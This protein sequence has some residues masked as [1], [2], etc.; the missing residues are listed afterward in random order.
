M[1]KKMDKVYFFYV[2]YCRDESLYA[3][4]TTDLARRLETHNEGKGAKYTR[5]SG[6]LPVRMIYAERHSTRSQAMSAE[7]QFKQLTRQQKETYLKDGGVKSLTDVGIVIV[8]RIEEVEE[9]T[10]NEESE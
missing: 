8:N 7:A 4:Y 10:H 5:A 3:G 9:N 1:D 6:R 2:L